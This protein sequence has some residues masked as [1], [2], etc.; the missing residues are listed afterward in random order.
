MYAIV[1]MSA[2]AI[3]TIVGGA[4]IGREGLRLLVVS[5]CSDVQD[6]AGLGRHCPDR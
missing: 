2:N 5:L 3:S 1:A 4:L 6:R